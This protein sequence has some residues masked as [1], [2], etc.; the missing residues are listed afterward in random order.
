MEQKYG[1]I[2][3]YRRDALGLGNTYL[4]RRGFGGLVGGAPK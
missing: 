3:G 2:Q 4:A 1:R